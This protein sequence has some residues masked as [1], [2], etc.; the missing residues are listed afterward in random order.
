MGGAL[1]LFAV[2]CVAASSSVAHTPLYNLRM[3]QVSSEM[4]FLPT[5]VSGF[6]YTTE[7]GFT[8]GSTI[9]GA[10]CGAVPMGTDATCFQ[11]CSTCD[12]CGTC[13]STC[14]PTCSY[15]CDDPTCAY[16]C[17]STC[18]D[19]TCAETCTGSTCGGQTCI[20]SCGSTCGYT[21]VGFQ[22]CPPGCTPYP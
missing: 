1:V 7:K 3:E 9:T 15:T 20:P 22:T 10:C 2:A 18:D 16:T 21:C 19:P 5:A 4:N 12:T 17:W 11:S 13:Y 8:V 14:P 6:F